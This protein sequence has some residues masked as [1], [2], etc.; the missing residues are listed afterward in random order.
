MQSILLKH[1]SEYL[2]AL[3]IVG[4]PSKK[5]PSHQFFSLNYSQLSKPG[6]AAEFCLFFFLVCVCFH[7]QLVIWIVLL[8]TNMQMKDS[9]ITANCSQ[10][11]P[12]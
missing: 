2:H 10:Y 4:A 3:L 5:F 9:D 8:A 6:P 7:W 1:Y 12:F 11:L